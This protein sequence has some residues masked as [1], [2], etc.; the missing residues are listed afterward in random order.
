MNV[1]V[2]LNFMGLLDFF[3]TSDIYE[4]VYRLYHYQEDVFRLVY[5][6]KRQKG[7]EKVAKKPV[8][9]GYNLY[10][11]S[12]YK[13]DIPQLK[14]TYQKEID[15]VSLS[16]TKRNIKEICLCNDFKYFVT[17]TINSKNAD[18]FSLQECQDNLKRLIHNYSMR[19]RR[20][21]IK[22]HYILITEKHK[23][24]AFHFHGLFSDL[25]DTDIYI[26]EYGY[27]SSHFFDEQLG[28][29]SF[30]KIKDILKCSNYITKYI[31]KECIKNEHNQIYICSKGLLRAE[32]YDLPAR[33][34]LKNSTITKDFWTYSNDFCKIKDFHYND[35]KDND[36][37]FLFTNYSQL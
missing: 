14:E 17:L 10:D 26:N 6:K 35:L 32:V 31:T 28:F 13:Y 16:R 3:K 20:K 19:F 7:F 30:S 12:D 4:D 5:Y 27:I 25:L 33:K 29:C 2:V 23:N 1:K 8:S 34:V 22:F 11:L 9:D 21:K 37:L 18:R 15:R 36:K 24:G